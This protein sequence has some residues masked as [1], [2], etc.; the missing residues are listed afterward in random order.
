V[1]LLD[2]HIVLWLTSQPE[3]LSSSTLSALQ[4]AR[5]R[6]TIPA[7]SA[8]TLLEIA[9]LAFKGRIH[10]RM[11]ADSL[12]EQVEKHFLVKPITGH[13]CAETMRLPASYPR[14]PIDRVIGATALVEGLTLITA[15]AAI[16]ASDA[17]PVI[18]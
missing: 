15:D 12:L 7:I 2:T 6:G 11:S 3:L 8:I 13:I 14:D 16:H 5:E 4:I 9:L 10:I 18:W 17:V 1:I